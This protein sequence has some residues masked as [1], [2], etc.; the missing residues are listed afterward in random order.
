MQPLYRFS[1]GLPSLLI[2]A[3]A[4]VLR[5]AGFAEPRDMAPTTAN[6]PPP[7]PVAGVVATSWRGNFERLQREGALT[8][9]PLPTR[10]LKRMAGRALARA[11]SSA[12]KREARKQKRLD[13]KSRR[14]Q[15]AA[16]QQNERDA[17]AAFDRGG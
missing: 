6:Q 3:A 11:L 9:S 7:T 13:A 8:A 4:G 5:R 10:Q 2:S 1:A 12:Q 14:A 16:A 15:E 17:Q